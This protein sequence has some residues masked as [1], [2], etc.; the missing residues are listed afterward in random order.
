VANNL[1]DIA[2]D[3][4]EIALQIAKEWK[5]TSP[6]TD[7]IIK[8]GCRTLLK[9][10]HEAALNLNGFNPTAKASVKEFTLSGKVSIGDRLEFGFT[11]LSREKKSTRFRLEYAIDFQTKSG[12]ISRKIFK[13]TEN[14]FEPFE[15]I[16]ILRKQSFKD[17][18][19][20]QHFKGRHRL[21]ILA[22][23][24]ELVGSEFFVT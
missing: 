12:K 1:N 15:H 7:W 8:H 23:G 18:T 9:R 22:N 3:H 21:R 11:F 2:K 16:R 6:E 24:R 17:L 4:P 20:R 19:T 13:L 10:G 14:T 5:G